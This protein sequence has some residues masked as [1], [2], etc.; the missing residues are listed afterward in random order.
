MTF[1]I[2]DSIYWNEIYTDYLNSVPSEEY[3][4]ARGGDYEKDRAQNWEEYEPKDICHSCCRDVQNYGFPTPTERFD[5]NGE[6]ILD[7]F[8][9]HPPTPFSK[10]ENEVHPIFANVNFPGVRYE[11]LLPALRLAS[12]LIESERSLD[13]F[14]ALWFGRDK[15]VFT[16]E[17]EDQWHWAYFRSKKC[18]SARDRA[19]VKSRLNT[20]AHMISFYRGK[21]MESGGET[22]Y[23][24]TSIGNCRSALNTGDFAG[25]TSAIYYSESHYHDLLSLDCL[26]SNETAMRLHFNFASLMG[27][28]LGHAAAAAAFGNEGDLPF[29]CNVMGEYGYDWQNYVFGGIPS[30]FWGPQ[31]EDILE[32]WP[33]AGI[34]KLYKRKDWPIWL[35]D[36][37]CPDVDVD[38]YIPLAYVRKLFWPSF[39]EFDLPRRGPDALKVPKILGFLNKP[40]DEGNSDGYTRL[41][42]W[43]L[44]EAH[45]ERVPPDC[46]LYANGFIGK[47]D[48]QVDEDGL[49]R[50]LRIDVPGLFPELLCQDAGVL[51][52]DDDGW[53]IYPRAAAA[54]ED[55]PTW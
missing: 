43:K 8:S 5:F 53:P 45:R 27:H 29:E 16:R 25:A 12:L 17:G 33:S 24:E 26:D 15:K 36:N 1:D 37:E 14:H 47:M 18:L 39:W 48:V 55:E 50:L 20:L 22:A 28:E 30:I 49:G 10:L 35:Q 11:I 21:K 44:S 23:A 42:R 2:D 32:E 9:A 7:R 51:P 38:W 19:M 6:L 34:G 41:T 52:A 46:F 31:S 13:F 4:R 3:E 40:T 54:N